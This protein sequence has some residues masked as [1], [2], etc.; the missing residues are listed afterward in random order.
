MNYRN[1][2]I[3]VTAW[4]VGAC[5]NTETAQDEDPIGDFIA[6]AEL[7]DVNSV[8]TEGQ[9]SF[10]HVNEYYVLIKTPRGYYLGQ[11]N[12]R[13]SA[14]GRKPQMG[15]TGNIMLR[16]NVDVRVNPRVFYAGQD[17]VRGCLVNSLYELDERMVD[18]LRQIPST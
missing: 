3:L 6:V 14:L 2:A 12:N 18:D 4:I 9:Y 16:T 8:R 1:V 11:L 13:C 5:A 7:Q 17:T 10:L 15:E